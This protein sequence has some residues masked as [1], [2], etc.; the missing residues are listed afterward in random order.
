MSRSRYAGILS[1]RRLEKLP[2]DTAR[3]FPLQATKPVGRLFSSVRINVDQT[4]DNKAYRGS[5]EGISDNAFE[6]SCNH[7]VE[8]NIS[9]GEFSRAK[10]EKDKPCTEVEM[11]TSFSSKA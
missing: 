11:V 7:V 9:E 4:H 5:N 3:S 6:E 10:F 8:I 2:L 1:R